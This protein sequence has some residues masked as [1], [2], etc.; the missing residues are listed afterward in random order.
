MASTTR[1]VIAFLAGAGIALAGVWAAHESGLIGHGEKAT[2]RKLQKAGE[3]LP[4][5]EI[6]AKALAAKPGRV[7]ETDFEVKGSRFTYEVDIL[8]DKGEFWEVEINAKTG[9]LVRAQ[10]EHDD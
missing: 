8:D 3:I 9:E 5:E 10:P 2:A 6:H 4:L 7:I 1:T